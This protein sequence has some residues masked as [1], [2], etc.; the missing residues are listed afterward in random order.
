[1]EIL[2]LNNK[3]MKRII[4]LITFFITFSVN[5]Q[6]TQFQRYNVE[7]GKVTYKK[8]TKKETIIK[9]I[10]FKDW[11]SVEYI[12]ETKKEFKGKKKKKLVKEQTT[13][14][15]LDKALVYTVDEKEKKIIQ[16]K[17]YGLVLFKNKNLTN[18]GKRISKANGGREVDYETIL[19]YDCEVWK[20]RGTT[21]VM[22]K[23]VPLKSVF[24]NDIEIATEA[25]FNITVSDKDMA[26]PDYEIFN[27]NPWQNTED[28]VDHY[29]T[30][31]GQQE[32]IEA[33]EDA[34][35]KVKNMTWEDWYEL[36]GGDP[37]YEN[38][39]EEEIKV[40]YQKEVNKKVNN[41]INNRLRNKK[42]IP[43]PW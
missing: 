7:T 29:S 30:E 25:K 33:G 4:V 41:R 17:N 1:M 21:T 27:A 28:A 35:D 20:L 36:H 9:T 16:V 12:V 39:T 2:H 10:I 31:E 38:L 19:G 24:R 3:N 34:L 40:L 8:E 15:K 22:Y 43:T 18:E 42:H 26:L 13:I 23:G 6:N 37:Q 11:G 14:T 32:V 5:S